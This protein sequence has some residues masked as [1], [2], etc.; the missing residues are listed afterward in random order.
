MSAR[1]RH[2]RAGPVALL[3]IG[4][5]SLWRLVMSPLIGPSCRFQPTCSAYGIEAMRRHGGLLGL[6]LTLRRLARCHPWGGHGHDPVPET[7]RLSVRAAK[8][9]A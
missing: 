9:G 1:S 5:F 6:W 8:D 7:V 4:I 3:F 2:R